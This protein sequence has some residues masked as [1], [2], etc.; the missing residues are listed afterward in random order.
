[1]DGLSSQVVSYDTSSAAGA[2]SDATFSVDTIVA[3]GC[4][5]AAGSG[6]KVC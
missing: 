3:D 4:H 1:M 2:A 5:A 6:A